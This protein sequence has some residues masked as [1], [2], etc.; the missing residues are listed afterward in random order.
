[1]V[2]YI[3]NEPTSTEAIAALRRS[4]GWNGMENCY[5]NPLMASYYHIACYDDNKLIGYVDTVS[6]GVTDAYIQD[7]AVDPAYQGQGVGTE[8]MNRIVSK[9]K[10]KKILWISVMYEEKLQDFYKR[11]GFL[12]MLSGTM[13]TYE[14]E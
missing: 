7:L 3:E 9:L 13:Q 2:T 10:E 5:N 12:Q 1:M 6:N 8:L 11:F 4:V 14:M